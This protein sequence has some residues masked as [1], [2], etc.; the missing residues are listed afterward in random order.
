MTTRHRIAAI[1]GSL[2]LCVVS[3]V[4]ALADAD[5]PGRIARLNY[6]DG[7]VT[8]SPAGTDQWA[9]ATLNRPL[10]AGDRLWSDNGARAELHVG[11]T[12]LRLGEQTSLDFLTLNDDNLQLKLTQGTLNFHVRSLW[13]GQSVEVDT[14]NLAFVV[15]QPGS[16]RITVDPNGNT[17][18]VTVRS[19]S[20]TAV[21]NHDSSMDIQSG[22]QVRFGGSDLSD[23]TARDLPYDDDF[24]HWAVDRDRHEDQSVSVRYVSRE[25]IGYED[26][27]DYGSWH[28]EAGY[29][30][31]WVP[32]VTV[33]NWAPYRYGHWAW[34]APWGW[35]WVDD[36][37]WGFAPF[38]YGRWAW[39]G[40]HWCWVPGGISPRPVYAPALVAFAAGGGGGGVHWGVSLSIGSPGVAWFPLG[41][42]EVYRPAYAVSPTYINNINKTVNVTNVTNI[43]NINNTTINNV[44]VNKTVYVNQQVPNAV[45]A[46]P[47][48]AFV[49]GKPVQRTLAA[50][51]PAALQA[52]SISATAPV[53]PVQQSM[54]GNAR[55][56]P[57]APA[58]V[59][60]A[61][62]V[63]ATQ[64][65]AQPAVMHD[66]LARQFANNGGV[67]QGA[68]ALPVH[69]MQPQQAPVV[70]PQVQVLPTAS[71]THALQPAVN[72][73]AANNPA[74]HEPKALDQRQ[75]ERMPQQPAP[76]Q[77]GNAPAH[78]PPAQPQPMPAN[79]AQPVVN[80]VPHPP[81]A[82]HLPP[83]DESRRERAE[84]VL[85]QPAQVHQEERV[86][87]PQPQAP[88]V[89]EAPRPQPQEHTVVRSPNR[90]ESAQPAFMPNEAHHN[91][92][93][94]PA[95]AHKE[96]ERKNGHDNKEK[97]L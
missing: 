43:T 14:P 54:T 52:A 75:A 10:T 26:L 19:G 8:F 23:V 53:A 83:M 86:V 97:E 33:T 47:A 87:H 45:T 34:V 65:P 84:P 24:D 95:P 94:K 16:Y 55:P 5:P 88:A 48:N 25:V 89:V 32:R 12:A 36:A 72:N 96:E 70:H 67:V 3:I 59:M 64:A 30:T 38:H 66:N 90:P 40:G 17:S 9:Y 13:D 49:Q 93:A 41:P 1:A 69:V 61:R 68:G 7:S 35:T 77:F 37:P 74:A 63:V 20:G 44:T 15:R 2:L 62:Q 50:V 60:R 56:A 80:N 6:F 78:N 21:G 31:V 85:G 29:G 46:V 79:T 39:A 22:E 82:A 58:A 76:A 18:T 57:V 71:V 27:D 92:E 11:S 91:Q 73:P 42:G 51:P 28:T 4:P 81:T